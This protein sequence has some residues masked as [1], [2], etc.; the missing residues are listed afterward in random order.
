[1]NRGGGTGGVRGGRTPPRIRDLF[2]KI[3][4]NSQ[5][6]IFFSIGPPLGKNRSPAPAHKQTLGIVLGQDSLQVL[7]KTLTFIF[8]FLAWNRP[9]VE[10]FKQN[11]LI[12]ITKCKKTTKII[13]YT[14]YLN[15]RSIVSGIADFDVNEDAIETRPVGPA[16]PI[17]HLTNVKEILIPY[18]ETVETNTIQ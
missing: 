1:M 7:R 9:K 8:N 18:I 13:I 11:D 16:I 10:I 12:N 2:S 14:Y 6:K 17:S 5:K 4:E 15:Y 3:F